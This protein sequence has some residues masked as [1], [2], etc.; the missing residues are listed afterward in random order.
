M[1]A[2]MPADEAIQA[3]QVWQE[4]Q[5]DLAKLSSNSRS[6]VAEKSGHGIPIDQPGLVI[7]AIRQM[8]E[9]SHGGSSSG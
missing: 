3:E 4:L 7:D 9:I 1:F 5:A 8:V 6:L 2:N